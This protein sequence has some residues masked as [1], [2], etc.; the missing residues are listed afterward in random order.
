MQQ[1]CLVYSFHFQHPAYRLVKIHSYLFIQ[2]RLTLINIKTH[3]HFNI[4]P[5]VLIMLTKFILKQK[6]FHNKL[7][8]KTV[9]TIAT[10]KW[11]PLSS[12]NKLHNIFKINIFYPYHFTRYAIWFQKSLIVLQFIIFE[13]E[14]F[15]HDFFGYYIHISFVI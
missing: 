1:I 11:I 9:Q 10:Y 7:T 14:T 2:N 4:L 3:K 6:I 8:T 12:Q 5:L 13:N 15:K